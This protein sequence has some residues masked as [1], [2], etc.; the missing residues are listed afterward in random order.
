M[1]ASESTQV[2]TKPAHFAV[3]VFDRWLLHFP[4]HNVSA[5]VDD[6]AMRELLSPAPRPKV[7]RQL[8]ALRRDLSAPPVLRPETKRG[9]FDPSY[10]AIVTTRGCNINCVYCDFGGPTST[11]VSMDPA[12]A[13]T[14]IDWMADHLVATGRELFFLH[15]FG[16]EPLIAG[17][18][19]DV[20]VHRLRAV[21]G[22]RGLRPFVDVS[23]NGVISTER[24]RW[25]GEFLD[26]V[27]LSFDG[28]A[29]F[30]NR[31]RSG[32]NGRSTFEVVD[33]TARYLSS[34]DI[35][36][37]LRACVTGESVFRMPEITRWMIDT[38]RPAIINFEPLTQND[39]TASAGL[40]AADPFAYAQMWMASKRI[41]DAA[42]VRLVYSAT[43]SARP[44]LSSCPVGSDAVM[45]TPDGAANGC[46]LQP[47]EWLKHGMDMS[48]GRVVPGQGLE[49]RADRADDLRQ[50]IL[51]KPRCRGCLCQWSCAGGCH[52]SNT[53]RN[54]NEEYID[55][56]IQTRIITACLLLEE[57]GE[58]ALV[59]SL[60]ENHEAMERLAR[61]TID[62]LGPNRT[63]PLRRG[64]RSLPIHV[65]SGA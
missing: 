53:Y 31:N 65:P 12:I 49:I 38:Y 29:E 40:S 19:V 44:R 33:R 64:G 45:V 2:A 59:E 9:P 54:C 57:L 26:S 48:L 63:K 60:L 25:V 21:C 16:G 35:E 52:V 34:T 51:D 14:A 13:V 36:L 7:D 58:S 15:L 4:L 17:D 28:P 22:E 10:L 39:L 6:A 43:E 8:Q 3:P 27:V 32:N 5:L 46:Y 56:C 20:A 62:S 37:C 30:Q 24:A 47:D 55:F 61:H 11:K 18:L 1:S 41:A 50:L 23:T 42:G